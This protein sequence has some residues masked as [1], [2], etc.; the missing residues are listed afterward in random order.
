MKLPLP[1]FCLALLISIGAAGGVPQ[2]GQAQN[3]S[4]STRATPIAQIK[5][6]FNRYDG[7]RREAQMNPEE[8]AKADAMLAKGLAIVMPGPD[9][10]ESAALFQTLQS[11]NAL[12]AEQLKKMELYPET[13][14]LH[15]GYYKYFSDAASL[16]GD[17]LRVQN[18]LM[19]TDPTTGKPLMGQLLNRKKGLEETDAANK[20]LDAELRSRFRIAPY[21]Y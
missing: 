2:F 5:D 21:R 11:K 18:N 20:A 1:S 8:R 12:A 9:K 19:T 6:W 15:R 14:Q 13:E 3:S 17:Y 4:A 10:V 16:F 7:V